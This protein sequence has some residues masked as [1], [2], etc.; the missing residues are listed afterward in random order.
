[1]VVSQ[2]KIAYIFDNNYIHD[3]IRRIAWVESRDG[4]DNTTYNGDYHG[5]LWKVDR[6]FFLMTQNI[7]YKG[8]KGK[9][10]LI[11]KQFSIDWSSLQWKNLRIPLWSG[12]AAY[13]YMFTIDKKLPSSYNVLDQADHWSENYNKR[14]EYPRTIERE[15]FEEKVKEL[16]D[17]ISG[18]YA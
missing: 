18:M 1:M 17:N 15:E 14:R 8:M 6:Q 2:I 7:S 9:H 12:L 3:Y 5:G 11:M 13:L 16:D 10:E 4:L